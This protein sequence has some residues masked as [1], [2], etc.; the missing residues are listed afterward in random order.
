MKRNSSRFSLIILLFAL[1]L[2][3]A[4]CSSGESTGDGS[5]TEAGSGADI[6]IELVAAD[7]QT[8]EISG[9]ELAKMEVFEGTGTFKKSTGTI[10]GPFT[11]KGV[12][13]SDLIAD[14][15][16]GASSAIEVVATDGYAMTYTAEQI[17]GEVMTYDDEGQALQIG[18]TTMILAYEMDGAQDFEGCPRVVFLGAENIITDGHFWARD[19]KTIRVLSTVKDWAIDLEGI[20]KASIDRATFESAA[21]CP[22]TN[23]PASTWE[24]TDKE[25]QTHTYEGIPLW[26]LVS[27]VDGADPQDGHYRFNDDLA[28]TGYTIKVLSRDGFSAELES[29]LVARN[30]KIMA[31]Y[32]KDGDY[33]PEG[34]FPLVLAGEDLPSSKHMVKQ[35]D[36]IQLENLPQ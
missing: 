4:A 29:Q 7:G 21:T 18:G 11:F 24:Y 16:A 9:A 30:S 19:V 2:V 28:R 12:K 32:K 10:E 6:T 5:N 25:G 27:M 22:D 3:M 13:M 14:A 34:E 26:V 1:V 33:L 35:I 36:K 31:A 8:K 23:H 20:E 15:G 17:A